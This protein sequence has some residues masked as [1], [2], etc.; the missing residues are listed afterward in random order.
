MSRNEVDFSGGCSHDLGGYIRFDVVVFQNGRS[1]HVQIV[2]MC[3]EVFMYAITDANLQA[4]WPPIGFFF[5]S[6]CLRGISRTPMGT[7]MTDGEAWIHF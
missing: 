5:F 7:V 1:G 4:S 2:P 3:G 6:F